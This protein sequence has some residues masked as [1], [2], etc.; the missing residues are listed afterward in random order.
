MIVSLYTGRVV[1]LEICM[2]RNYSALDYLGVKFWSREFFVFCL[3]PK[4]FFWVL[5]FAPI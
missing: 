5:I 2:A 4:I 1:P 3:K